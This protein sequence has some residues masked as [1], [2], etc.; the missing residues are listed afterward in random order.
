MSNTFHLTSNACDLR[1]LAVN[2]FEFY[3]HVQDLFVLVNTT[4]MRRNI[5]ANLTLF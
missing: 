4:A 2:L 5:D 3:P 1:N